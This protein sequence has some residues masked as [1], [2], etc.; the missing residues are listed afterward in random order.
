MKQGEEKPEK[1]SLRELTSVG[2]IGIELT[3]SVL[4]GAFIGYQGDRYFG[5]DPWLMVF[6]FFLGAA[7]GY[8]SIYKQTIG[9]HLDE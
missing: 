1:E 9:R 8:Y 6:G 2:S 4:V 7:A 5:T 3:I